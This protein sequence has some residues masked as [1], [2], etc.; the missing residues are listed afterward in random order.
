MSLQRNGIKN[1]IRLL[2]SPDS[3]V[4]MKTNLL[5]GKRERGKEGKGKRK[6]LKYNIGVA[7][8]YINIAYIL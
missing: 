6:K 4:S 2:K 7:K 3:Y 1:E 5:K 8:D